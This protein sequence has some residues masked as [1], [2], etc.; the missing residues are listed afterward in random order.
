MID[1]IHIGLSEHQ[2]YTELHQLLGLQ[3][4][5]SNKTYDDIRIT[6]INNQYML[7]Y[8]M[9]DSFTHD[10]IY[11]YNAKINNQTLAELLIYL[12]YYDDDFRYYALPA[13]FKI[14]IQSMYLNGTNL[15]RYTVLNFQ[16]KWYYDNVI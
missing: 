6:Q 16:P 10:I 8:E 4:I 7:E 2:N 11:T 15:K 5:P 1:Q 13:N 14:D 3:N 9:T 12:F